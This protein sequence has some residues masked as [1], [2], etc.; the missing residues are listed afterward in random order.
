MKNFT[1]FFRTQEIYEAKDQYE[2]YAAFD[3]K[4]LVLGY[5]SVGQA[6]LPLILRHIEVNP[7]N[8]TVLEKDNHKSVFTKR[9]ANTGIRYVRK[10]IVKGNYK[11][12]LSKYVDSGGMIINCCLNVDAESLLKWCM[13]ND[14]MQIDTS[15]ERWDNVQDEEIP[16]LADRTLYHTHKLIRSQMRGYE[17]MATCVVTHGANPGMVTHLTKRALLDLAKSRGRKV[18]IP[19]TR[20]DWAMLM[21]LLGVKVVHIA[22]RDTQIIDVPKEKNEFVNTWS[23]EG[24]WAEGRAPAEMGW[25]THEDRKPEGGATQGGGSAAYLNAPGV[26]VLLKS[27][28]PNGGQYNGFCVQHSESI[29]ISQYF[30]T[31][32]KKFR[33]SVYYVYQPADCAITSVHEMRGHELD[34]QKEHRIIKD[35]IIA[36]MDELGILLIGDGFCWWHGSQMTIEDARRLIPGESATSVQVAGSMLAAIVW[37]IKNPRMGYVEPEEIPFNEIME[38]SD[39]YWAPLKSVGSNWTPHKD[40]NSLFYREF[41]KSN[42]CKFENFRVWS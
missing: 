9:H 1:E 18:V 2:K 40:E 17:R 42:P 25:G 14:I 10:E 26:A 23:C 39:Q 16:K 32:D 29:T 31:E 28:V 41:D 35:E 33:P 11:S 15:L 36:G 5:G 27:W 34:M 19:E 20:E 6:I 21:K 37:M 4:I 24:F 12:E 30:T 3:G 7:E 38:I 8:I 13:S 22:E